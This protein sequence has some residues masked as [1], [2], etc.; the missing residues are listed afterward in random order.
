MYE[1]HNKK[2]LNFVLFLL[3]LKTVNLAWLLVNKVSLFQAFI[4]QAIT[5]VKFYQNL[6]EKSTYDII[7]YQMIGIYILKMAV[8]KCHLCINKNLQTNREQLKKIKR[9]NEHFTYIKI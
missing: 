5:H 1:K 2:G 3:R 6:G 8:C 7:L 4:Q 9:E